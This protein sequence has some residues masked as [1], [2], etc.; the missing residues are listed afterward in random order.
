MPGV[1][2]LPIVGGVDAV[3][4]DSAPDDDDDDDDSQAAT[5]CG[6]QGLFVDPSGL[7][8][9]LVEPWLADSGAID[10]FTD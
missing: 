6:D 2:V 9:Y 5:D 7:A 3:A 1:P 4:D 10:V 8:C